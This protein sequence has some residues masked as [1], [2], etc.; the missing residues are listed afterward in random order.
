MKKIKLLTPLFTMAT[1]PS[2]IIPVVTSCS[3][4]ASTIPT[5]LLLQNDYTLKGFKKDADVKQY[6]TLVIPEGIKYI[7]DSAFA[8]IFASK[9][10]SGSIQKIVFPKSLK[11]IRAKAFIGCTSLRVLDFSAFTVNEINDLYVDY[12][13]T[14]KAFAGCNFVGTIIT[15]DLSEQSKKTLEEKLHAAGLNKAWF[16]EES[17][18]KVTADKVWMKQETEMA[19]ADYSIKIDVKLAATT[20]IYA[21]ISKTGGTK[22]VQAYTSADYLLINNEATTLTTHMYANEKDNDNVNFA[23]TF[24]AYN[25]SDNTIVWRQTIDGFNITYKVAK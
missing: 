8:N 15:K 11:A 19:K 20:K 17:V 13:V 22:V 16:A 21:S 18:G 24:V 2:V 5:N 12:S 3:N 7:D 1:L 23:I 9:T 4:G 25:T 10:L 14:N 6:E